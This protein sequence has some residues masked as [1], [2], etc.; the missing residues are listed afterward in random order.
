MALSTGVAYTSDLVKHIINE[1]GKTEIVKKQLE[2][3]E[4]DIF[5]G[6]RF[7]EKKSPAENLNFADLISVDTEKLQSAFNVNIDQNAIASE[8]AGYMSE[9]QKS[10]TANTAPAKTDFMNGLAT[11]IAALPA[12]PYTPKDINGIVLGVMGDDGTKTILQ[13][14][15]IKYLVPQKVFKEAYEGLLSGLLVARLASIEDELFLATPDIANGIEQLATGM[16]EAVV[17]RDVLTKVGELT[18]NL[19]KSFAD[20]FSVDEAKIASSFKL[21]I[22]EEEI[23]RIITAMMSDD[24]ATAT[25]NLISLGYQDLESP[26]R[27]SF[28][29]NSFDSKEHFMS[30]LDA[31]NDTMEASGEENKVIN[32]SDTTGILMGSVKTIVNAVS[33]VLIGFVS[34]SLV[35]SSIMIGIITYISVYERTKEIGILRAIGASKRNI[36]NIFNA[37]TFI[38]GLLSGIFGLAISFG[39]IVIINI[40][41]KSLVGNIPLHAVLTINNAIALGILSVILT[42]IGGLIPAKS[43]SR[44]DPVEALRSE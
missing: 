3:P 38:V 17:K 2:N 16:T 12:E 18:G 28:Y 7:D 9:I 30:F 33:Y 35:V 1:S 11:L 36:S 23:T 15:E 31:Y 32:Y 22:T 41:L 25:S 21:A 10:I 13:N 40:I 34:V 26:T 44:K 19:T 27:I 24:D 14:L 42:L 43:A 20:A 37:E 4:S 8:T 5:S 6:N 39:L 29:F